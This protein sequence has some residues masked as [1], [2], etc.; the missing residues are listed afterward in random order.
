LSKP[1]KNYDQR[2]GNRAERSN[3]PKERDS[4]RPIFAE[5][6]GGRAK[7]DVEKTGYRPE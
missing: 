2:E 1:I 4:L 3:T 7:G 6:G 5:E